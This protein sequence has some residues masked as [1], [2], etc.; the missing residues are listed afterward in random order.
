MG[1]GFVP[2][3]IDRILRD[4]KFA[5]N[6]THYIRIPICTPT[7][8]SQLESSIRRLARDPCASSAPL[9]AYQSLET[10]GLNY[11]ALKLPTAAHLETAI[12]LARDYVV[13]WDSASQLH[14]DASIGASGSRRM[15]TPLAVRLVGLKNEEMENHGK[16]HSKTSGFSATAHDS[17]KR[18]KGFIEGLL[19]EFDTAGITVPKLRAEEKTKSKSPDQVVFLTTTQIPGNEPKRSGDPRK[20]RLYAEMGRMKPLLFDGQEMHE[21]Y[22]DHVWLD[23][24]ELEKLSICEMGL[25]DMIRGE[26]IIGQGYREVA[27]V[28]MPGFTTSAHCRVPH[29][30]GIS[31][32]KPPRERGDKKRRVPLY[33]IDVDQERRA[34][35]SK[36][37]AGASDLAT[38]RAEQRQI[39]GT[40]VRR[41]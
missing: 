5:H 39:T 3:R 22:K 7:S 15:A 32:A 4:P 29:E 10:L 16:N 2:K 28:P 34:A 17:T 8:R 33:L 6:L 23:N 13:K 18:F 30:E 21:K 20:T 41:V 19:R 24:V 37:T 11:T 25:K 31:F 36:A 9:E 26:T 38:G 35:Q 27:A 40:L 12:I 1:I 14:S